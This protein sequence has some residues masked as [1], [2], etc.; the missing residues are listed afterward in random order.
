MQHYNAKDESRVKKRK[1]SD[2]ASSPIDLTDEGKEYILTSIEGMTRGEVEENNFLTARTVHSPQPTTTAAA[3]ST[4][5]TTTTTSTTTTTITTTT[6]TTTTTTST[7]TILRYRSQA[8]ASNS[9]QPR[10]HS[11][12]PKAVLLFLC[13]RPHLAPKGCSEEG[14]REFILSHLH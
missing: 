3:A 2:G 10:A 14:L 5:T 4:T 13:A 11:P 6:T 9:P 7:A 1:R 8:T 12:Q